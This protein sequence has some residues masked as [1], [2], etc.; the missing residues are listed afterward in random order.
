MIEHVFLVLPVP[1]HVTA[2]SCG[3]GTLLVGCVVTH[4]WYFYDMFRLHEVIIRRI[5][6][7]TAR[8]CL[9]KLMPW[10]NCL[11]ASPDYVVLIAKH[12]VELKKVGT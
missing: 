3:A 7:L 12:G 6:L 9:T 5:L 2:T 10:N 1:V 8:D 4:K 11:K